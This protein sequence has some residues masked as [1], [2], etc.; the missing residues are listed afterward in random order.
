MSGC[1][2]LRAGH[3]PCASCTRF[4]PNTR[5]PAA[6]SGVMASAPC[7][8]DTAISSTESVR[9]AIVL[10][11]SI[12]S[13]TPASRAAGSSV[14]MGG[15]ISRAVPRRHPLSRPPIPKVWLMTDE[16]LGERLWIAIV[17]LPRGSG[18]VFRHYATPAAE[19]RRLFARIV[20]LAR[21]RGLVVVRAGEW[22]GPGADGVHNRSGGGIRSAAVQSMAEAR[23]A[24]RRGVDAV[25]VSPVFATRSHPRAEALGV[26]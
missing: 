1:A 5:C 26:R 8:L 7:V 15:A 18:I 3:L 10:A 20:W 4:S 16:R 25:F 19:R 13:R 17:R 24:A 6:I 11:R 12:W 14:V 9:A 21:E 2:A 22:C 23:A